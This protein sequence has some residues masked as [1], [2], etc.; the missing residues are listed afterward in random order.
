MAEQTD[1]MP[2]NCDSEPGNEVNN[3]ATRQ[4]AAAITYKQKAR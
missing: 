3:K 1:V 2:A 4:R